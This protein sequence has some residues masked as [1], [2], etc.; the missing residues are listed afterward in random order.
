MEELP[1]QSI[2]SIPLGTIQSN[3]DKLESTT[4]ISFQFH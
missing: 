2:V 3:P 4:V 1:P